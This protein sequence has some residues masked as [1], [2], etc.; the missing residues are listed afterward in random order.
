MKEREGRKKKI[1]CL[2]SRREGG[3]GGGGRGKGE[4]LGEGDGYNQLDNRTTGKGRG[5]EEGSRP[6]NFVT[7]FSE[8][9]VKREKRGKKKRKK[10]LKGGGGE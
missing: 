9:S 1:L 3:G 4:I 5:R 6:S 2:W 10:A 8:D 7:L